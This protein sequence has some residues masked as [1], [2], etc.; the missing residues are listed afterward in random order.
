M[1]SYIEKTGILGV[2]VEAGNIMLHWSSK[3]VF[4]QINCKRS[5]VK[6]ILG[7]TE[8]YSGWAGFS[9]WAAVC[10]PLLLGMIDLIRKKMGLNVKPWMFQCQAREHELMSKPISSRMN[11]GGTLM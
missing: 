3:L 11:Q 8:I 5:S 9:R 2:E 1:L 10:Q 4:H 6:T 7:C